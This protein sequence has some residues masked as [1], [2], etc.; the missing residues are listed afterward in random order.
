M[1]RKDD[2]CHK[3]II[4][5]LADCVGTRE[6]GLLLLSRHQFHI[7]PADYT[8]PA[9]RDRPPRPPVASSVINDIRQLTRKRTFEKRSLSLRG[10][11]AVDH[12]H[13]AGDERRCIRRQ[14][15]YRSL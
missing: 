2:P 15:Y 14:K 8:L 10:L 9:D 12:Q 1:T 13:M 6:R 5:V 7:R 3:R 11:S 4:E